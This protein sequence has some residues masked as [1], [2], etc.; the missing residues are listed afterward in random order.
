MW[1]RSLYWRIGSG[2]VLLLA[3]LLLVQALLVLWMTGQADDWFPVRS[4]F[5]LVTLVA[6]DVSKALE[7]DPDI[8]LEQYVREEFAHI[9]QPFLIVMT[10]GRVIQSREGR[11]PPGMVRAARQ[12]LGVSQQ[13][14]GDQHL[15]PAQPRGETQEPRPSPPERPRRSPSDGTFRAGDVRESG[16]FAESAPIVVNDETVGLV[17]V[18]MRG[19]PLI[20]IRQFGPMLALIGLALLVA[21][22]AL[23]SLLI[24]GPARERMRGL[25]K[26]AAA[27]GA[28]RRS[29]RA[30]EEGEDEVTAVARAFNRMASQL[31]ASDAARRRLLA[32]VSH[33]LRTPLTAIR[34]YVETLSMDE[35]KLDEPTR[36]RYLQIVGD[37]TN[38]LEAI[39]GDLLDLSRLEAGGVTLER[40]KVDVARLFERIRDRHGPVINDKNLTLETVID[41]G[42][43][44]VCGDP[45]RL[46]QAL[47]NLAANAI[48]HSPE[49]GVVRFHAMR[50]G[51]ATRITVRD[52]G[53]GI[54]QEHLPHIFDRFYKVQFSR[55]AG[56]AATGSGL[57]LSIVK[58]IVEQ[59]R[60][61]VSAANRAGGGAVFEIVLPGTVGAADR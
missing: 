9:F 59:H 51:D 17:V 21:G 1:Y 30:P 22:A 46:E 19:Q 8:S 41:P 57:G 45:H 10:D 35:L 38:K 26:A 40:Q 42:A 44:T 37:E 14:A 16:P 36:K 54:P 11:V 12:R 28:G 23:G 61:T 43:E 33:E 39:V 2:F 7:R 5:R 49:G 53:P 60:G 15:S 4:P 55:T 20:F 58:A 29:V 24:F 13:F 34:G 27:I 31:E 6:S 47:Q 32:D 3:A 25:E 18:S 48:R 52:E 50:F 56:E